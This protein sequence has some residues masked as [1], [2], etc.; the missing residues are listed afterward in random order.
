MPGDG[1]TDWRR[2]VGLLT[3]KGYMGPFVFEVSFAE[4]GGPTD[5][6]LKKLTDGWWELIK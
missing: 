5:E 1:I 4:C 2:L 3:E 6:A